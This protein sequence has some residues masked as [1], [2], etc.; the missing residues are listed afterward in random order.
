MRT[1]ACLAAVCLA[2]LVLPAAAA[3]KPAHKAP[4]A[5]AP[6]QGFGKATAGMARLDGLLPV[7]VDKAQGKI[8]L[9]LPAPDQDGVAGRF[10]YLTALKTGLGSA[11][12]GLDRSQPGD[13]QILVFRRVGKKVI[14]EYENTKFR[15]VGAPAPEQASARDS[16]A[17]STVWAGDVA[18]EA[19]DGRILVDIT[20]FI[21]RDAVD[22][23]GLLKG[24]GESGWKLASDLSVAD[25]ASVKAF[26]ENIVFDA[27]ETFTTD[28]VSAEV[29]NIAP[30]PKSIS[31]VV[32]HMLVKLPEP[33][34]VPRRFDPRTGT[35]STQ[36]VD[37]GSKLGDPIVYELADRFRLEKLDPAAPRSRV[38][39][40][41]VFYVD[42][43]APEP[44][45]SA[46]V[47]GAGWWSKAF[48]DAGFIDAF[49]VE[50]L[51]EGADPLDVR[52]NVINWVDRATRGWSY[53][54]PITDPRTGEIIKGSVL[55]GSLRIRQD[56]LIF[57]GL[58]GADRDNSGAQDDPV[59]ISLARIRQLGAHETG[60]AL[61]F[62]HNFAGS[63]QDRTSVMDYPG[64]RIAVRDGKLDFSDAYA[65]GI[66]K[67]D[68][69]TV[70]WL[71]GEPD[72]AAAR[73]KAKAGEDAGL[74]YIT[75]G[76][77]RPQDAPQPWASLWDDGPDPAAELTHMM[78]VRRIAIDNFG[79]RALK[80]GEQVSDL[81]RKYVPVF[82]LHRY[83]I[84]A[85]SKL[86]AGVQYTYS[87]AGD[88]RES[89]PPVAAADQRRALDALLATLAPAELDTPERLLPL[90]SAGWSGQND[91]QVDIEVFA[92]QGGPVFDPLVAADTSA[93]LT[94]NALLA[95][96]RLNRL[97]DQHRRDPGQPGVEEVLDRLIGQVW[98]APAANEGR[99]GDVRRRVETRTLVSLAEAERSHETSRE[100][101]S[102]IDQKVL[103]LIER[104]K[105]DRS[106]DAAE[107]AHRQYLARL[108]SDR[109]ELERVLGQPQHK[110][111][112]PPGM[113]IGADEDDWMSDI[114]R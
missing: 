97:A 26:P 104:L 31:F 21:A 8:L 20:S 37:Y 18:G 101:A 57:E 74:R 54:Q 98:A 9:S 11:P 2:A 28:T 100:V 85:A 109:H 102:I 64:P 91:R 105:G 29:G 99:L 72:D 19:P 7:Y 67:W 51:P 87:V 81:R 62:S 68:E 40:P 33:G 38:K 93:T 113:P 34:F 61:G 41:I 6:A 78:Q 44:I 10:I 83:E 86:L 1:R 75:D 71:Y 24:N 89:S 47:E 70:D 43:A 69:F 55:L 45:R 52:Y 36:V 84:D 22:I 12:L 56:M 60:H 112:A 106:A 110:P 103:A 63:T 59:R 58:A 15:A 66:G 27:R 88:G 4:E 13:D 35:F 46:L 77:A 39:K 95:P 96:G 3:A 14:A 42:R 73:A 32:R 90:L 76:D 94:L 107:R 114:T 5:A 80:D 82:L 49:R 25:P 108:I 65:T 48:D 53:G 23:A 50:V 92:T 17:Y 111:S 30:T 16:F 79:L